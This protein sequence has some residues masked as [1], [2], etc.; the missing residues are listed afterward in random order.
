MFQHRAQRDKKKKK[1]N[2]APS[3]PTQNNIFAPLNPFFFHNFQYS[4]TL[5]EPFLLPKSGI[6]VQTPDMQIASSLRNPPVN[7]VVCGVWPKCVVIRSCDAV[8]HF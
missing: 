2:E 3:S 7:R 8:P 4:P 6:I 5:V 1:Q